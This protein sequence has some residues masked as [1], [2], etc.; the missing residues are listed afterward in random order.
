MT[1]KYAS[2]VIIVKDIARSRHFYEQVLG[3]KVELD[4]GP[5]I[6]F[7]GGFSIWQK[8]HAFNIIYGDQSNSVTIGENEVELYFV[9]E[10][11]VETRDYLADNRVELVHDII[12]QPWG[13]RAF[14][15]YD[16]DRH[17]IEFGEPME[18]VIKRFLRQGMTVEETSVRAS[19]P[20]EIVKRVH[21][22]LNS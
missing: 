20:V 8:D 16:P 1:I 22:S 13:Q 19:M 10:N 12:E 4:H 9:T 11:A 15:V 18:E 3:Q 6:S 5:C 14:R 7:S 17:V 2:A 21:D